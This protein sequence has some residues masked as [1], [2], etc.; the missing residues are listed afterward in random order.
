MWS[1]FQL[2]RM[3]ILNWTVYT[4]QFI[5]YS[6]YCWRSL[7]FSR[8][9][10]RNLWLEYGHRSLSVLGIRT[11]VAISL[12]VLS[13]GFISICF[14]KTASLS[15]T[16]EQHSSTRNGQHHRRRH[17][18]LCRSLV[19]LVADLGHRGPRLHSLLPSGETRLV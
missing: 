1:E 18:I 15:Q 12:A 11:Y 8:N 17:W 5:Q 10:H 6:L 19:G 7:W 13:L 3:Y 9:S 4:E 2:Y 14:I 16:K